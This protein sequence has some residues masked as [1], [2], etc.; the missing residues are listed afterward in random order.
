MRR[1]LACV[2]CAAVAAGLLVWRAELFTVSRPG[3]IAR[4]LGW[5]SEEL[6]S[7]ARFDALLPAVPIG[8]A[9]VRPGPGVLV[10]HY[11]AP[12]QRHARA[13]IVALDS[14]CRGLPPDMH[15][16]VVCF[17]PFPSV[18]RMS[19]RLHL[20]VP[21]LLDAHRAL[22]R[23]LPCPSVPYTYVVDVNGRI[24][25]AQAGEVEWLAPETRQVLD[26]MR[27]PVAGGA[28]RL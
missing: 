18:A 15:V 1:A 13:Q 24:V 28:V 27:R 7:E 16:A 9:R 2:L 6:R 19:A 5:L 21:I 4:P 10:V 11:W 25:A 26:A 12:W 23:D 20:R 8:A 3:D 17:D 14:L 22:A